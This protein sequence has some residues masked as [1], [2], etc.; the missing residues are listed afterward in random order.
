MKK[1]L[2]TAIVILILSACS[3]GVSEEQ[4]NQLLEQNQQLIEQ[5]RELMDKAQ[6]PNSLNFMVVEKD[7]YQK[8]GCGNLGYV[9]PCGNVKYLLITPNKEETLSLRMGRTNDSQ[10]WQDAIVGEPLPM[11]CRK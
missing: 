5:N 11:S 10:C 2:F 9:Y 7:V 4:F 3:S 8:D 6:Q 1:I